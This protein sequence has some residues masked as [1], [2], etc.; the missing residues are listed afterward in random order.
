L[1][2]RR[3][4]SP[5]KMHL[6]IDQ[7]NNLTPLS[8]FRSSLD[9]TTNTSGCDF[10]KRTGACSI[11]LCRYVLSNAGELPNSGHK[12][13]SLLPSE[14]GH[15]WGVFTEWKSVRHEC[16]QARISASGGNPNELGAS[17]GDDPDAKQDRVQGDDDDAVW[18]GE[19]SDA[20]NFFIPNDASYWDGAWQNH[21]GGVDDPERRDGYWP[22]AFRPKENPFYVALPYGEFVRDL[23]LKPEAQNIPW[24]R[25]GLS[26][27]LK[28]RWVG[29]G[30]V[31]RSCFAQW[32][33]VGP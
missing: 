6:F 26:P 20:E 22:A 9:F 25:R 33:D 11:L 28:N 27:L 14:N 2:F 13:D 10:R 16:N 3:R 15:W 5:G 8:P 4:A 31:G 32:Q 12:R 19:P 17:C 23:K 1:P 7:S 30:R 18:V 29:I 24:Y 21:F